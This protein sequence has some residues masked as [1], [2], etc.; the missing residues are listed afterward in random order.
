MYFYFLEL[1]W[2]VMKNVL[3]KISIVLI[4]TLGL[5]GVIQLLPACHCTENVLNPTTI[6]CITQSCFEHLIEFGAPSD[7]DCAQCRQCPHQA[8][9]KT[10]FDINLQNNS[11]YY[12]STLAAKSLE[13]FQIAHQS[14]TQKYPNRNTRIFYFTETLR[15]VIIRS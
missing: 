5:C 7:Q 1:S 9:N 13:S 3:K 11:R 2:L 10:V 4:F 14:F 6:E 15:T 12:K 8:E